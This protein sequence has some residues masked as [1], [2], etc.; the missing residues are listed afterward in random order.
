[1]RSQ[2]RR[3]L[4]AIFATPVPASLEWRRIEIPPEVHARVAALAAGQGK[5]LNAW[6]QE[7]LPRAAG[8]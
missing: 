7:V 8:A 2:H 5:S 1:M 4:E 3:T 6:A